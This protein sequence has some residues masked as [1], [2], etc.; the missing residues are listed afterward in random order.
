MRQHTPSH[1]GV[2]YRLL[3][4]RAWPPGTA[5]AQGRARGGLSRCKRP[6]LAA[7]K[8]AFWKAKG[9]I[10]RHAA[11]RRPFTFSNFSRTCHCR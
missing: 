9:R 3:H 1:E 10:L 11:R 2:P 8:T 4:S 5:D 6:P 7:R